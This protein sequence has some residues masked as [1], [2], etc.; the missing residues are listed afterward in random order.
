MIKEVPV[1]VIRE[2]RVTDTVE[3]VEKVFET[4]TVKRNMAPK[5]ELLATFYFE[6]NQPT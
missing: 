4:D 6:L 3:V 2:V 5:Y 1:E